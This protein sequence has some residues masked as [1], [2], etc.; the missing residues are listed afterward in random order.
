MFSSRGSYRAN[1]AAR[2]VEHDRPGRS[3]APGAAAPGEPAVHARGPC[4]RTRP[5][6]SRRIDELL[7]AVADAGR[8][9]V[10]H[11]LAAQLP[12]RLTADLLGFPEDR[13]E[14]IK[15]WSERL[16][17][18]DSIIRDPEAAHGRDVRRSWSS[19]RCS[20]RS[21]PSARA[22]RPTTSSPCGPAADMDPITM[23][24][25][26]GLF[27]AG[28]AETT[29]T[30]IARGLA[31]LAEHPDQW[32]A[33]AAD[34]SLV[35][36]PGGGG[37]P[38]GDAAQQHVPAASL[39]DDHIGDAAGAGGRPGDARLP[40][41]PTATRPC[42]TSRS[43]STSAVTP[44]RTSRS[45]RAPTSASAPTWPASS[46]ACSSAPSPSGGRNLTIITP[47]DI[48]PNIFAG[49]VRRFDLGFELR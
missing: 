14:D 44:T 20:R 1:V 48:E 38:L 36:G 40:V 21:P 7:D 5:S 2:G 42:S 11:D 25:E 15:S 29:R 49:A 26:T 47:P 22:A 24:H 18:T 43:A 23:M 45:G 31:I 12:S 41:A 16:M 6:S 13:W 30:V 19:T 33:A 4:S 46:C 27:I 39:T 32:E 17:R 10:V 9:E 3:R 37:H 8:L 34:P 28:G 35:A